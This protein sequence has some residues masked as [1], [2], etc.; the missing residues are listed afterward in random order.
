[1]KS[2]RAAALVLA[3][4]LAFSAAAGAAVCRRSEAWK[5]QLAQI[6]DA[7]RAGDLTAAGNSLAALRRSWHSAQPWLRI[8]CCHGDLYAF[9]SALGCAE[10][11]LEDGDRD[12]LR[13]FLAQLSAAADAMAAET[14]LDWGN[15]L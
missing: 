1:M 9:S 15:I 5:Q 6:D 7:C 13:Q 3:L 2:S 14:R 12:E 10:A 4:T 11:A 8:V